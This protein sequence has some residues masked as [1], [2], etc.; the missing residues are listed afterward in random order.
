MYK[1]YV[2]KK[3]DYRDGQTSK[4]FIFQVDNRC[5][6]ISNCH[7]SYPPSFV[8]GGFVPVW[9]GNLVNVETIYNYSLVYFRKLNPYKN[10]WIL[11]T[12]TPLGYSRP[13]A[14]PQNNL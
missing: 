8:E 2:S 1:Y 12:N 3:G 5:I 11:Y 9:F 6:K 10:V 4:A 7:L 14:Q 13:I